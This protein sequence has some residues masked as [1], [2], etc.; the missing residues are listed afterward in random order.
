[1]I[2]EKAPRDRQMLHIRAEQC[3]MRPHSNP[4][5]ISLFQFITLDANGTFKRFA[6]LQNV[7]IKVRAAMNS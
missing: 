5:C 4:F 3:L 7:R 6:D 2:S 1:M